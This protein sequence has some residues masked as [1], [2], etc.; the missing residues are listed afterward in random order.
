M[1][2]T[3]NVKAKLR[4]LELCEVLKHFKS[5]ERKDRRKLQRCLKKVRQK[6]NRHRRM[7]DV[8]PVEM[9]QLTDAE[10]KSMF[11]LNRDGFNFLLEKI[12]PLIGGTNEQQAKNSSGSVITP[13]I[14]LACT[15][16][17][18]AG[19]SFHDICFGWGI[20]KSTFYSDGV[21]GIIWPTID[22]ID[23]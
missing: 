2:N 19:G 22:A 13:T 8:A 6:G 14:K 4:V 1:I 23:R 9:D 12:E 15:L 3:P 5:L 20:A 10:F 17:Y 11:R 18:L 7:R 21:G 16:R